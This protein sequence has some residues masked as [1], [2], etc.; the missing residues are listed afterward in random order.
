[1]VHRRRTENNREIDSNFQSYTLQYQAQAEILQLTQAILI[2]SEGTR[3]TDV[4]KL[5]T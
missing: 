2:R 5:H 1:M 4:R 3:V